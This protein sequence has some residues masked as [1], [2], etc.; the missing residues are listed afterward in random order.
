MFLCVTLCPASNK[1]PKNCGRKGFGKLDI[2]IAVEN[3]KNINKHGARETAYANKN[4]QSGITLDR[5]IIFSYTV[6]GIF[7]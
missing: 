6:K 2:F 7:S 1:L 4:I 5:K 3:E